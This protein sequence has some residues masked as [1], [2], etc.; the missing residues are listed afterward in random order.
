[1]TGQGKHKV[2]EV[3]VQRRQ[4]SVSKFFA[5]LIPSHGLKC[6]KELGIGRGALTRLMFVPTT[7][8]TREGC[9]EGD[10]VR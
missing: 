10:R 1:M 7:A 9:V 2:R 3:T 6:M 4:W 5:D 8:S